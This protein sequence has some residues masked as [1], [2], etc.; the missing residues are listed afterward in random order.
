VAKKDLEEVKVMVTAKLAAEG[1]K[2]LVHGPVIPFVQV[3]KVAK[4]PFIES[5]LNADLIVNDFKPKSPL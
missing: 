1:T 5:F 2:E 3:L 4:C